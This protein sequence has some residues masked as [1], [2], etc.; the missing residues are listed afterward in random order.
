MRFLP[1]SPSFIFLGLVESPGLAAFT[2]PLVFTPFTLATLL[3]SSIVGFVDTVGIVVASKVAFGVA[4][5]STT[6]DIATFVKCT[7]AS[8][9]IIIAFMDTIIA[10]A[11]MGTFIKSAKV[12]R[13]FINITFMAIRIAN[14][15]P[16][17]AKFM[18]IAS[19]IMVMAAFIELAPM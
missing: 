15:K 7:V 11:V 8:M 16:C 9:D 4:F 17:S 12:I 14:F 2:S 19:F 1:P 5:V 18:V 13:C 6:M 10:F 3:I